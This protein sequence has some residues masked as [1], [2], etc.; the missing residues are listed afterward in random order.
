MN[1]NEEEQVDSEK[2][3][4]E[5]RKPV[6]KS[7]KALS[8]GLLIFSWM[9][10]LSLKISERAEVKEEFRQVD[11]VSTKV[12]NAL[13]VFGVNKGRKYLAKVSQEYP[14]SYIYDNE[15]RFVQ[16]HERGSSLANKPIENVLIFL[17]NVHSRESAGKNGLWISEK[18]IRI[19]GVSFSEDEIRVNC[20]LLN[21]DG[22]SS[23]QQREYRI[24]WKKGT[25][26]GS[27]F[28]L[29]S[30]EVLSESSDGKNTS[31]ESVPADSI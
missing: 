19:E 23:S 4:E 11:R 31:P 25:D 7:W 27:G 15:D 1:V 26:P 29:E 22:T 10:I 16:I 9:L 21:D 17:T 2:T 13:K 3:P 24:P 5:T 12:Y 28:L 6:W 8:Y 30:G 14:L 18:D 20:A